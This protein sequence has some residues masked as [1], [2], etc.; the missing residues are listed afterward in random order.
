M[1]Y[2]QTVAEI[3][4]PLCN[5]PLDDVLKMLEIPPKPEMGD[6]AFPCFTLAKAMRLSPVQIAAN[7]QAESAK[8]L[9]QAIKE[10]KALGPYVNFFFDPQIF[11]LD[12]V[13]EINGAGASYG[14]GNSGEGQTVLIEYSSPNIAKPFHVGHAFTTILG[15]SLARLY[16][17]QSYQ[18]VRLNHLGDYGTQFGKL[19]V[20]YEKWGDEAKLEAEPIA[21]LLR[22][23]VKFHQEAKLDESLEQEARLRFKNLEANAPYETALWQKFKD[24]SLVEFDRIYKRLRVDFD[25]W[26]GESFYSNMIAE[27]VEK[28]AAENLLETSEGAEVVKL[29]EYN[30]PPCLVVKSDG[31]TIYA[32][33]D[34]AAIFYRYERWHFN[35]NIYVVG[36]PQALH[37]KQVFAVLDKAGYDFAKD[38]VHVGFGLVKFPNAKFS[39][40]E[41]N[42]ILL[43]D[44][45]NE[46][47]SKTE[48]IIRRNNEER[49]TDMSEAEIKETAEKI[50]VSAIMYVFQKN[51]R[52]RDIVFDWDEILSFEGETGPY[53]QYTYS[54]ALSVLKKVATNDVESLKRRLQNLD[55]AVYGELNLS[56]SAYGLA[57]ALAD[58]PD[59]LLSALQQNE[60]FVVARALNNVARMFNRFYTNNHI[61]SAPERE[62]ELLLALCAAV[63][64]VLENGLQILGM[65][66]VERM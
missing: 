10:V 32:S 36:T 22:I 2:K 63:C 51:G 64:Q 50:G 30:L 62:K 7:L 61:I 42:V 66:V 28:L 39:T 65:A 47:V 60:L 8:S 14:T 59:E 45:L 3:L 9:P 13:N 54:R 40:R 20:A 46:A 19:I 41:G 49:H 5:L 34:L 29:D 37:F 12:T 58:Y 52:E 4:Q 43:E 24:L 18:V 17:S 33:R 23:Y 15:A 21:E 27:V 53:L 25:C 1:D 16:G 26:N 6:L 56:E 38:C 31:T 35:K 44:L 48:Q 57:K 11:I 55:T